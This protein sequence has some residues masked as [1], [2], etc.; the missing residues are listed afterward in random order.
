M[1]TNGNEIIGLIKYTQLFYFLK[2]SY[3]AKLNE[4]ARIHIYAMN[5]NLFS[6]IFVWQVHFN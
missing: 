4:S 1:L 5:V 3:N 2:I 6:N